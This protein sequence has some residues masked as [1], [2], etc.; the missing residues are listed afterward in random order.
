MRQVI[1]F[2][3]LT[4]TIV[5]ILIGTFLGAA[6]YSMVKTLLLDRQIGFGQFQFDASNDTFTLSFPFFINNTGYFDFSDVNLTTHIRDSNGTLIT[7]STTIIPQIPRGSVGN[8][9][10]E[11]SLSLGEV[12]SK[13]LTYMLFQE[14]NLTIESSVGFGYARAFSFQLEIPNMTMPWG[15]PLYNISLRDVPSFNA[16]HLNVS[17]GFEN[18]SPFNVTGE[19]SLEIYNDQ[20]ELMGVGAILLDVPPGQ[21]W[22]DQVAVA[23]DPFKLT[24][25]GEVHIYIETPMFSF[26][27]VVM[28]Y[29]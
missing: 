25:G 10:H 16:T 6:G 29:G 20:Q 4:V 5:M 26:G 14:S 11:I 1:R 17:L 24:P 15:P 9:T 2:L 18:R 28:P 21:P 22:E 8:E 12:I 13:N 19:I 23:V 27:P 7:N 3:G